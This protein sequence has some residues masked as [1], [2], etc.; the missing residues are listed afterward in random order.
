MSTFFRAGVPISRLSSPNAGPEE[1]IMQNP[2]P[3]QPIE[4]EP[5]EREPDYGPPSMVYMQILFWLAQWVTQR[6]ERTGATTDQLV[7]EHGINIRKV[8]DPNWR[9]EG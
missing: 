5:S 8:I 2:Y 3:S 1:L 6:A 4:P 9:P 7:E